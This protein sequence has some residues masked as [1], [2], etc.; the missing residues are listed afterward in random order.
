MSRQEDGET[1]SERSR[2]AELL[3]G[4]ERGGKPRGCDDTAWQ[5]T[6][7]DDDDKPK[8]R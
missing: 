5:E 6:E 1:Q 3:R 4:H 2:L 8:R 7:D